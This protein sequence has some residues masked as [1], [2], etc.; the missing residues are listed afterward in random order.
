M[1]KWE[2]REVPKIIPKYIGPP[3]EIFIEVPQVKLVDKKVEK[4]VPVYVGEKLVKKEVK[5][6][7]FISR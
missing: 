1:S 7:F 4:E 2:I 6:L 5:A 3:E